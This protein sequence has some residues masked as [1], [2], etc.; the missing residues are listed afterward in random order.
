[1]AKKI[2]PSR[3]NIEKPKK[4]RLQDLLEEET[5]LYFYN[6]GKLPE[7]LVDYLGATIV[8]YSKKPTSYTLSTFLQSKNILDSSLRTLRGKYP[9]LDYAYRLAMQNIANNREMDSIIKRKEEDRVLDG[10]IV[11]KKQYFYDEQ[12]RKQYQEM[13]KV[14]E[15]ATQM[16]PTKVVV[17]FP[18]FK[19]SDGTP[20]NKE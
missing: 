7:V 6:R 2:K 8:E 12:Y 9:K 18:D 14:A 5:G 11:W 13:K 3:E 20:P 16:Q 17:N 19:K 15:E 1:M 4:K 10:N